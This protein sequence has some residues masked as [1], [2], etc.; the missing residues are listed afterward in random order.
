[1]ANRE[2]HYEAAFEALLRERQSTYLPVDE[3]HRAMLGYGSLKSLDF[4]LTARDGR[5]WL[6]DVKGRRFPAGRRQKQYWR[7]WSTLDDVDSLVQWEQA[8]GERFTGLF[9]FA[10]DVVGDRAPL[11]AEQLFPF[12]HRLYGFIGVRLH[13]YAQ[14]ATTLSP[15][16]GTLSVPAAT[17]RRLAEPLDAFL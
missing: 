9:V 7:N 2:N 14:F 1:M 8:F 4:I 15:K 12:R 17:F 16:W 10:Y 6:V 3:A 5:N 11:P 13:E